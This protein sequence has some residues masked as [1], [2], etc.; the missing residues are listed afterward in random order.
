MLSTVMTVEDH[1][2]LQYV[3]ELTIMDTEENGTQGFA[4]RAPASRTRLLT[5][6]FA[7]HAF[8]ERPWRSNVGRL[9]RT[10]GHAGCSCPRRRMA[11][12][13][14]TMT[15]EENP[16]FSDES[17]TKSFKYM[18]GEDGVPVVSMRERCS[19]MKALERR[20]WF[21]H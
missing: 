11:S 6:M 5:C 20:L 14:I 13:Q 8:R 1:Q 18:D 21:A 7:S 17:V 10:L 2:V 15:F 12:L 9:G 16:H 3:K 19:D 4:V